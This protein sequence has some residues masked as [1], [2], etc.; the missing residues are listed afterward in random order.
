MRLEEG[1]QCVQRGLGKRGL[2]R[3]EH[4]QQIGESDM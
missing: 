2:K 3:R 1:G 4:G